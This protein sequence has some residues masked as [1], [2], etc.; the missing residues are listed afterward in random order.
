[1]KFARSVILLAFEIVVWGKY[2]PRGFVDLFSCPCVLYG[3]WQY[4]SY[5]SVSVNAVGL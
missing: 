4:F 5:L 3:M 2:N 1:M